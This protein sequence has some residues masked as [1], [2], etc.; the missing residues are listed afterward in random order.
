M[1]TDFRGFIIQGRMRADE[2]PVGVFVSGNNYQ[3]QCDGN[4]SIYS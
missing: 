2:S 4:V 3:L 1:N